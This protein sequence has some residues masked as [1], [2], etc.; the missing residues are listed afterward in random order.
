MTKKNSFEIISNDDIVIQNFPIPDLE[1][2]HDKLDKIWEEICNQKNNKLFNGKVLAYIDSFKQNNKLIIK[3]GFID[4]KIVTSSRFEPSLGL[5]IKQIGVSGMTFV[6]DNNNEYVLF[7]TRSTETT[8]YPNFLELVP[9]GNIDESALKSDGTID[10]STK[11]IDEFVEETGLEKYTIQEINPFCLVLD[12][13]NQVYD[14]CCKINIVNS[15]SNI[16]KTFE[17]VSEYGKPELI[18]LNSLDKFIEQNH[19]KII[20][21]SLAILSNFSKD[22]PSY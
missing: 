1:F 21:T 22:L 17:K 10:F 7:S 19:S 2:D 5:K 6:H 11:L 9:S 3:A 4:Y 16:F 13:K 8:E 12:K 20:P 15:K 14:V 18:P